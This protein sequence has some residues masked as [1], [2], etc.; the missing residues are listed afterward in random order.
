MSTP[1]RAADNVDTTRRAENAHFVDGR[2]MPCC[3]E[4]EFDCPCT[5]HDVHLKM[6]PVPPPPEAA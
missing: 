5:C 2:I 4:G 6:R 1:K 3:E